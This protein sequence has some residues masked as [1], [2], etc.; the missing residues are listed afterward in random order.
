M[1]ENNYFNNYNADNSDRKAIMYIFVFSIAIILSVTFL[2]LNIKRVNNHHTYLLESNTRLL[3]Q[4]KMCMVENSVYQRMV[5]N[6]AIIC[7]SDTNEYKEMNLIL[8][9]SSREYEGA[10]GQ[11]VEF[12]KSDKESA[13]NIQLLEDVRMK[14][15]TYIET[16]DEF[17]RLV[18]EGKTNELPGFLMDDLRPKY[19]ALQNIHQ[20]VSKQINTN[21]IDSNRQSV[22]RSNY[23]AFAMLLIGLSP[24]IFFGFKMLFGRLMYR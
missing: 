13:V 3:E 7:P 12:S 10:F 21:I 20:L 9:N 2:F 6:Y 5:L 8:I 17:I 23:V 16:A 22:E 19:E 4:T 18:K 15:K 11:L 14:R 1:R 24:F